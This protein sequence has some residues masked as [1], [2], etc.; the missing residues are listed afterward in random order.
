MHEFLPL[1]QQVASV[2]INDGTGGP[3][4]VLPFCRVPGRFVNAYATIGRCVDQ[5]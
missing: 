1:E 4:E 3:L 5:I 2:A